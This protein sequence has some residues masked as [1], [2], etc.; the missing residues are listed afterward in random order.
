MLLWMKY[1]SDMYVKNGKYFHND[2]TMLQRIA[3]ESGYLG[4]NNIQVIND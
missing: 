4:K 3:D 2:G 1:V